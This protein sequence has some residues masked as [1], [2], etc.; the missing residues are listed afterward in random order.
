[1]IKKE[2]ELKDN[3]DGLLGI[4]LGLRNPVTG[5]TL[6]V[7]ESSPEVLFKGDPI[8]RIQ[9][10]YSY[11]RRNS[12]NGKKWK[13]REYRKVRDKLHKITTEL[14]D[15]A[16]K[17]DLIVIVGDLEG[18]Q[19]QDKGRAMNRKLHRFPHHT[20]RKLLE[21]K[22]KE[23]GVKYDEVS[24]ANTSK[25]CCKCGEEGIRKRGIFKCSG[26]EMNSDVNGA[27][28]ISKRALGKPEIRSLLGAGASVTTPELPSDDLTSGVLSG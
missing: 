11:L 24:E 5:V 27:W 18:I 13:E 9:T 2:V 20:F 23:R 19:N 14:A 15:Y 1:M 26:A 17:N 22:C 8:K 3:F 25:L 12:K 4:D 6:S 21:Y 16:E 7:A 10:Y 28:N